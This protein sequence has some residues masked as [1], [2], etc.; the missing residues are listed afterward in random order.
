MHQGHTSVQCVRNE[1]LEKLR[2]ARMARGRVAIIRLQAQALEKAPILENPRKSIL[3]FAR[4]K[5][6]RAEQPAK[7]FDVLHLKATGE[8]NAFTILVR[9]R[10]R[11][12]REEMPRRVF[13]EERRD[14]AAGGQFT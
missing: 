7:L 5:M 13:E 2:G 1:R 11:L 12:H 4:T 6:N 10:H 3:R 14:R 8:Q 9:T